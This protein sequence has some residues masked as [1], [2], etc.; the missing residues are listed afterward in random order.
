MTNTAI[1]NL[2][3]FDSAV[4]Y[5]YYK[6]AVTDDTAGIP[7][8]GD[9]EPRFVHEHEFDG[10]FEYPCDHDDSGWETDFAGRDVRVC[11]S[12]GETLTV[13]TY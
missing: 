6:A 5:A 1:Q 3:G 9:E 11:Y 7:V 13:I 10:D 2:L 4:D 12:C 8:D